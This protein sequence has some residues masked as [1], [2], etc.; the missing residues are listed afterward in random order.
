MSEIDKLFGMKGKVV[1]ITGA[2]GYLGRQMCLVLAA[3]GAHVLI[4][5]RNLEDAQ[6]FSEELYTLGYSA[7]P[8]VFDLTQTSDIEDFF[9][10]YNKEK[11]N[12]LINN[13]YAGQAGSIEHCSEESYRS[14][15]EVGLVSIHS[16]LRLS[17]PFLRMAVELD[18]DASVINVASMY[19]MVSPD[20]AIYSNNAVA[21][22]PYYGAVKAAL[23]QWTKYAAGEFGKEGIRF[24]SISP[25][26]FPSTHVRDDS[27]EFVADL[28]KKSM[29]GRVGKATEIQ[30]PILFL[31]SSAS[32][33]LTGSNLVVD[34]G[35]T[36][37]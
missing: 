15:F 2:T 20:L 22:P 16:L 25:G 8:V 37:R 5:S 23:I 4:N 7:E 29:F 10:N 11:I 18:G 30:G 35:W 36:A 34:G 31:S 33:Y 21:N 13:A 19:G 9:A 32:S 17:L 26:A 12:V 14:S 6:V 3:A 1:L 24:N 28:A 27:S